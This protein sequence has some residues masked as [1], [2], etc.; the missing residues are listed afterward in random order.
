MRSILTAIRESARRRDLLKHVHELIRHARHVR[1]MRSDIADPQDVRQLSRAISRLIDTA[2]GPGLPDIREA[3]AELHEALRRV[4]PPRFAPGWR[5]N[6]EVIAV[7]VAV[8]MAVRTYFIQPFK[9]PTGSM[10]TTLYGIHYERQ[11]TPAWIDRWPLKPMHWLVRGA[12]YQEFHAQATGVLNGPFVVPDQNSHY[13][14]TIGGVN[15]HIPRDLP[16]RGLRPGDTVFRGQLLTSGRRI[17]GDHIFVDKVKWNFFPPRRGDVSVFR[18]DNIQP[19]GKIKTHYIKRLVGM[20]GETISIVPPKIL[21]NG[22]AVVGC[23]GLDR[24]QDR[25]PGYAGY[26][27]TGHAEHYLGRPGQPFRL[28]AGEYLLLGD[29]T[30]NSFDGRYWGAVPEANMMGPAFLVYWPFSKRWGRIH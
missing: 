17:I 3:E 22:K 1:A 24:N 29:N 21:I 6:I 23:P 18:T 8:A 4:S 5:E 12:W 27:V 11:E 14:F 20:P 16:L 15:H 28:G 9:I 19:I 10:Q 7:A 2:A 26:E 25:Q 30:G 13:L